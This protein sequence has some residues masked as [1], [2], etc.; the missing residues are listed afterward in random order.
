MTAAPVWES[1]GL[2]WERA[3]GEIDD[4]RQP[5]SGTG[6]GR[7]G[8]SGH[9]SWRLRAAVHALLRWIDTR[10]VDGATGQPVAGAKVTLAGHCAQ[11]KREKSAV[12]DA[13]GAVR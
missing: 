11:Y 1:P 8:R 3:V 10:I 12:S 13:S 9:G 7:S 2:F 4:G 5:E 6:R